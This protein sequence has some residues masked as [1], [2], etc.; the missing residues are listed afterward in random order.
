MPFDWKNDIDN[1]NDTFCKWGPL[2]NVPAEV[3]SSTEARCKVPA[4]TLN[5]VELHLNLTLNNQNVTEGT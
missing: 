4:N 3:I 1:R 2:G 5:L